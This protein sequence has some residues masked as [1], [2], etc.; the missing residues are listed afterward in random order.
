MARGETAVRYVR[1]ESDFGHEVDGEAILVEM[2]RGMA[3][4]CMESQVWE[5]PMSGKQRYDRK[6][7]CAPVNL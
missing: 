6:R 2:L 1:S 7:A 5:L 3:K 4:A